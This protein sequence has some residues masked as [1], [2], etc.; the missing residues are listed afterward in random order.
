M[1]RRFLGALL[2]AALFVPAIAGHAN[3]NEAFVTLAP[4]GGGYSGHVTL[5]LNPRVIA[6]EVH[7]SAPSGFFG[8]DGRACSDD[9]VVR[10]ASSQRFLVVIVDREALDTCMRP[11][12]G[13]CDEVRGT[14]V[15][16]GDSAPDEL[17]DPVDVDSG[18]LGLVAF[19]RADGANE[20]VFAVAGRDGLHVGQLSVEDDREVIMGAAA[21]TLGACGV[22]AMVSA[23]TLPIL[24]EVPGQPRRLED[25]DDNNP[26]IWTGEDD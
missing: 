26:Y 3:P 23:A 5:I 15:A 24:F 6:P 18:L 8:W 17:V 13:V 12:P 7:V 25:W 11:P 20:E 9:L 19:D 1:L 21:N 10:E 4:D 22:R 16:Q 2:T 14:V